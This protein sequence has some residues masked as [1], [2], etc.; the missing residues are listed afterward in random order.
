MR[1]AALFAGTLALLAAACTIVNGLTVPDRS[2][3]EAGADSGGGDDV[4]A[5]PIDTCA[6]ALPPPSP[7]SGG[8]AGTKIFV[9]ALST[10]DLGVRPDAGTAEKLGFD[11]DGFCTC[12]TTTA[13]SCVRPTDNPD[14]CDGDGGVDNAAAF[15]FQEASAFSIDLTDDLRSDLGGGAH[16]VLLWVQDYNGEANDPLVRATVMIASGIEGGGKP[17]FDGGVAEQWTVLP[18]QTVQS[19]DG[20]VPQPGLLVSGYVVDHKIVL[21]GAFKI[22]LLAGL[23]IDLAQAYLVGDLK[24]TTLTPGGF[25]IE[26][27]VISGRGPVDQVLRSIGGVQKNGHAMCEPEN[28]FFYNSLKDEVCRVRDVVKDPTRDRLGDPCNAVSIGFT[29]HTVPALIG[30][31]QPLT[32]VTYC[33]DADVSCPTIGASD[34]GI[35]GDGGN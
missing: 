1:R 11:L 25:Y 13:S 5:G 22:L 9:S 29:F 16:G 12:G 20:F 28:A 6:H 17:D 31:Q 30:S 26:N 4:D 7:A 35:A 3:D 10:V 23:S 19:N 18:E 8:S 24:P 33:P 2:A 32:Q 15:L 27:G 21:Q 14:T 34:S